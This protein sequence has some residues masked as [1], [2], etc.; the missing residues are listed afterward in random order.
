MGYATEPRPVKPV[1]GPHG[2]YTARDSNPEPAGA[3]VASR[4]LR[5][6][7]GS[8][9]AAVSCLP[10]FLPAV[11]LGGDA[12]DA[13]AVGRMVTMEEWRRTRRISAAG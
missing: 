6:V 8:D 10:Q 1:R 2:W 7:D 3:S 13:P 5:L 11:D 4:T 9:D 12:P